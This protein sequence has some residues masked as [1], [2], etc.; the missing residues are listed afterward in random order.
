[1]INLQQVLMSDQIMHSDEKYNPGDFS[2]SN[3]SKHKRKPTKK[4]LK[5]IRENNLPQVPQ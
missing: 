5:K 4:K 2:E 1:M 3:I